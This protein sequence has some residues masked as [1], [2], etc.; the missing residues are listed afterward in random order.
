[1]MNSIVRSLNSLALLIGA[2]YLSVP[3]GLQAQS[4]SAPAPTVAPTKVSDQELQAFARVYVAYQRIRSSYEARISKVP[5][6]KVKESLRQEGDLKVKEVLAK[7]GLT[8]QAYNRLFGAVKGDAQLR[9][10]ALK[11]IEAERRQS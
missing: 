1:M 4:P 9:Q 3:A 2:L 7:Q 5:D 8:P 6:A 11:L 10:K